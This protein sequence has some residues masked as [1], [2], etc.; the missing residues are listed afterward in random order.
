MALTR[1]LVERPPEPEIERLD[2]EDDLPSTGSSGDTFV[3]GERLYQW[4]GGR[5]HNVADI[6]SAQPTT[7]IQR[8]RQSV[9]GGSGEPT[10]GVS[11]STITSSYTRV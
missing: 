1:H 5:W 2:S 11:G 8:V 9:A 10:T 7:S 6:R 3:L 4:R